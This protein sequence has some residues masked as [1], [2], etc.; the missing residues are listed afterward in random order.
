MVTE[1][2]PPAA[3]GT[4]LYV[5]PATRDVY[6]RGERVRLTPKEFA[7]LKLLYGRRG[8]TVTYGVIC[9]AIWGCSY[10]EALVT[11]I[12]N[13]V[14]RVRRKIEVDPDHPALIERKE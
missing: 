12:H 13:L 14:S 11:G 7:L 10:A 5:D 6:V 4:V 2:V 9:E 3:R 1:A 8:S